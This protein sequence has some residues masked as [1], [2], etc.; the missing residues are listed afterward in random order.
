M[1]FG[2]IA[3]IC[4]VSYAQKFLLNTILMPLGLQAL[5]YATWWFSKRDQKKDAED[6][7]EEANEVADLSEHAEELEQEKKASRF[8]DHYFAFFLTCTRHN[9]RLGSTSC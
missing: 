3:P 9:L 6:D 5:V 8:G 1:D 4:K 7:A 2:W